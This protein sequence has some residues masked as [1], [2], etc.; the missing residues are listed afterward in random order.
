M[1]ENVE[2]ESQPIAARFEN[3]LENKHSFLFPGVI[4][5]I[6]FALFFIIWWLSLTDI[7]S[8]HPSLDPFALLGYP[9]S[10]DYMTAT[11]LFFVF[12][13]LMMFVVYFVCL[14][15][16]TLF[17]ILGSKSMF[18]FGLSQDIAE[19]GKK[20]GGIQ[21][22]LRS[23]LPGLFGI[24][25]G[26]A[27]LPYIFSL[28]DPSPAISPLS[29]T[30]I[31]TLY[32]GSLGLILGMALFP[33]TWFADDSGLVIQGMLK[34]PYRAP[35]RVDGTGNWLRSVFAGLTVFLYPLTMIQGFILTPNIDFLDL[36]I[37]VFVIIIGLPLV[38]MSISIPFVLLT[39]KLQPRV[40]KG[41]YY[42]AQK[43]GA[44]KIDLYE[45]KI[46]EVESEKE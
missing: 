16:M 31:S 40:V 38:M 9:L 28:A 34:T 45:P 12:I 17:V 25:I 7:L 4:M 27:G 2:K 3:A 44:K 5:V 32:Y 36:A 10:L 39:E 23:L 33:A 11:V 6:G 24:G 13:L 22:V 21:M 19:P 43:I 20:F 41:I 26:V 8:N 42:V 1:T 15:P 29:F 46:I 30:L 35:P 18:V 37:G 14:I